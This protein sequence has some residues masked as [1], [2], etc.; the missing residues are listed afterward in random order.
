MCSETKTW[1]CRVQEKHRLFGTFPHSRQPPKA[2]TDLFCSVLPSDSSSVAPSWNCSRSTLMSTSQELAKC[3]NS[4]IP[5]NTRKTSALNFPLATSW[6][7]SCN[8]KWKQPL[9]IFWL[10]VFWCFGWQL[11]WKGMALLVPLSIQ[12]GK[13]NKLN[14]HKTS[15]TFWR[16]MARGR[17]GTISNLSADR[18]QFG[19]YSLPF[20]S[21]TA[22]RQYTLEPLES[23]PQER[24]ILLGWFH[25]VSLGPQI[26]TVPT[27][28]GPNFLQLQMWPHL[29]LAFWLVEMWF[30]CASLKP[31]TIT[32][33]QMPM[34]ALFPLRCHQAEIKA[35]NYRA[36][37][38]LT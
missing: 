37:S 32:H 4:T 33:Q 34:I 36:F 15:N 10:L 8:W 14:I 31:N 21:C 35:E 26:D 12:K 30:F 29:N 28:I 3:R 2:T 13:S 38:L 24:H 19:C 23:V 5:F 6:S 16:D 27:G 11:Q 22:M 18:I 20:L 7:N 17:L 1:N 25:A 9:A